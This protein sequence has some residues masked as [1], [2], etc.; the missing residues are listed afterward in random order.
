MCSRI[1]ILTVTSN[2]SAFTRAW[3]FFRS[4]WKERP[5]RYWKYVEEVVS[6]TECS[7]WYTRLRT[8]RCCNNPYPK[9]YSLLFIYYLQVTE[10]G[11]DC[12][13]GM[14]YARHFADLR[15]SGKSRAW[16]YEMDL[17]ASVRDK[18]WGFFDMKINLWLIRVNSL[19]EVFARWVIWF[20]SKLTLG[21]F[22]GTQKHIAL[23]EINNKVTTPK[24]S[25]YS[26]VN[27]GICGVTVM[28]NFC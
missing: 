7:N 14:N 28:D 10:D 8:G 1:L 17:T 13:F 23:V 24:G 11:W 26:R 22:G 12:F 19:K 18:S 6:R 9:T 4:R 2:G 27:R 16:D 20:V 15:A 5:A 3:L 25:K 21:L